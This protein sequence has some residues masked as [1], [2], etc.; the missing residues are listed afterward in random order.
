[1]VLV[2]FVIGF[3]IFVIRLF[4]FHIIASS[5]QSICLKI[6][7]TI[8]HLPRSISCCSVVVE[9]RGWC[10]SLRHVQEIT[11]SFTIFKGKIINS[12]QFKFWGA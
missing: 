11:P 6:W 8:L 3:T 9:I 4:I 2:I 5:F 12:K 7:I 1:M 10:S